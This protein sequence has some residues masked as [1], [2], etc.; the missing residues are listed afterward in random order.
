MNQDI[1]TIVAHT[2]AKPG[3][4]ELLLT[5]QKQLVTATLKEPGCLR[6]ELSVSTTEPGAATFVEQWT[7]AAS[8]QQ[9]M[10]SP[11]MN[12]FRA[13][14]GHAIDT[15]EIHQLRQVA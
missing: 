4:E 8:W 1:L 11:H 13:A 14:A 9:H 3:L 6:Y 15:L 12:D 5:Q 2:R 7:S 10:D